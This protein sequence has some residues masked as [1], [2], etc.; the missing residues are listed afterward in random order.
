MLIAAV[1]WAAALCAAAL[2]GHSNA[3]CICGVRRATAALRPMDDPRAASCSFVNDDLARLSGFE[4]FF[5]SVF[6]WDTATAVVV[7]L[8]YMFVLCGVLDAALRAALRAA[9]KALVGSQ[10]GDLLG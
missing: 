7:S 8:V 6:G 10:R 2:C 9:G 1:L 5:C 3:V 4:Y